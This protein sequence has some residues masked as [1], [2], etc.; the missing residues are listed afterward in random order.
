MASFRYRSPEVIL[1]LRCVGEPCTHCLGGNANYLNVSNRGLL[2]Y[3]RWSFP[4]DIWSVGCI[5][6]EI[7]T[8]KLCFPT[9]DN[10]E[11]LALMQHI[12]GQIPVRM[13]RRAR[14]CQKNFF[15]DGTLHW[16]RP[17][18]K[19]RSVK[20]VGAQLPLTDKVASL[21][22]LSRQK[23]PPEHWDQFLF[24]VG[25]YAIDDECVVCLYPLTLS[26]FVARIIQLNC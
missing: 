13:G 11:H 16:P 2:I 12:L 5:V 1:G 17:S 3:N 20:F 24:L 19:R 23:F 21:K 15:P 10:T 26:S 18:A 9:H 6:M 4:S 22:Q 25:P 14:E 7:A 8:G